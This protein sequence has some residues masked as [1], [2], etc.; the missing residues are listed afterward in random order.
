MWTSIIKKKKYNRR[1][2]LKDICS[3][4]ESNKESLSKQ[5][6]LVEFSYKHVDDFFC[7]S[8]DK[9][10]KIVS[11]FNSSLNQI[12]IESWDESRAKLEAKPET[13]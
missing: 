13:K 6:P 7:P 8:K 9:I 1:Q 3:I 2:F 12:L 11:S 5:L 4:C 10:Y